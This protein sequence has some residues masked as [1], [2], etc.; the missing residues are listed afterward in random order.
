MNV[1]RIH[2]STREIAT[3]DEGRGRSGN[4]SWLFI[5]RHVAQVALKRFQRKREKKRKETK[6]EEERENAI[7]KQHI[8]ASTTRETL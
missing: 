6:R 7:R 5:P 8:G 2:Q 1:Q 3:T 4:S